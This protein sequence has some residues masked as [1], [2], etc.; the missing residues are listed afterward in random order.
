MSTITEIS[1][2]EPTS[3]IVIYTGALDT[4]IEEALKLGEVGERGFAFNKEKATELTHVYLATPVGVPGKI[5]TIHVQAKAHITELIDGEGGVTFKVDE[6]EKIDVMVSARFGDVRRTFMYCDDY[7]LETTIKHREQN[8]K[9]VSDLKSNME[10]ARLFLASHK[11]KEL[12]IPRDQ[13]QAIVR[14]FMD[15]LDPSTDVIKTAQTI[16]AGI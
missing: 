1:S 5:R 12:K 16:L 8:K 10:Q 7:H 3:A 9:L 6:I 11:P 2:L 15:A 4:T 14:R 13:V